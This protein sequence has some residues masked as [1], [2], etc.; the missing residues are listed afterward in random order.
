[1]VCGLQISLEFPT[2][3]FQIGMV[4]LARLLNKSRF[5]SYK[6]SAIFWDKAIT[7]GTDRDVCSGSPLFA[8][9][10]LIQSENKK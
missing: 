10:F 3:S 6:P 7:G 2:I 4:M 8:Y 1:M 9:N 5:N